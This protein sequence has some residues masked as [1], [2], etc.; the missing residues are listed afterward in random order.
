MVDSPFNEN[1]KNII[2][3]REALISGEGWPESLGKGAKTGTSIVRQIGGG[4][5]FRKRISALPPDTKIFVMP[6]FFYMPHQI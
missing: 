1:P 6:Q 3:S 2:F 4:G 5:E